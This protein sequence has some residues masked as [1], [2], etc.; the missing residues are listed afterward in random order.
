MV[1]GAGTGPLL[2]GVVAQ[3]QPTPIHT[4]F[5]IEIALLCLAFIALMRQK[6]RKLWNGTF[7][8]CLPTVP[9]ESLGIVLLGVA[10]FGPGITST[11][12]ILSLGAKLTTTYV[13]MDSPLIIG[14]MAFSM[15]VVAMGV[16]FAAKRYGYRTIFSFSGVATVASMISV[17]ISLQVGSETWL[18]ASALLAGTGQGLGQLGGAD[19]DR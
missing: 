5:R 12:F 10:F 4:V 6:S 7:K 18:V 17:W 19:N 16:Q 3:Y 15:F 2:A 11:S 1:L 13:E 14:A 9:K 8:P